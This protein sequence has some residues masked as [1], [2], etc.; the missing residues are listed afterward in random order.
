[1]PVPSGTSVDGQG[2]VSVGPSG[3]R[4]GSD[5]GTAGPG[6]GVMMRRPGA[7]VAA[8]VRAGRDEA[9]AGAGDA[10]GL[11]RAVRGRADPAAR[12]PAPPVEV[13]AC[14]LESAGAARAGV[15]IAMPI[16]RAT[17]TALRLP[18]SAD[19][20]ITMR[21]PPAIVRQRA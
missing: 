1:M 21:H 13:L 2:I 17:A 18:T 20:V 10:T 16:P 15:A 11:E 5:V 6:A 7:A 19:L 8:A 9:A 12:G 4:I 14:S 3:S